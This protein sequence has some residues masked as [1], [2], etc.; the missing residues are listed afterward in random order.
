VHRVS[1]TIG[2]NVENVEYRNLH[3]T[4]WDVGGQDR[5][6]VLW[7][8]YYHGTDALIFVVDSNDHERLAEARN[9]LNAFLSD[10]NMV[11]ALVL[12]FANKMDLPGAL[13]GSA[14]A[15]AMS[16]NS[17]RETWYIQPLSAV[18]SIGVTEGLEW[19][20]QQVKL[21]FA[22]PRAGS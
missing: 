9:E 12:V 14:V 11:D 6:R 10:S 18:T 16:L 21:R 5:I 2:F 4:I 20:S 22:K 1:L 17:R 15:E 3:M 8:H 19:L 7:K 13:S